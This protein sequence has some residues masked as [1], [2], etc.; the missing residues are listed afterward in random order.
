MPWIINLK[1]G[2]QQD[3]KGRHFRTATN[4]RGRQDII[5]VEHPTNAEKARMIPV[6]PEPVYIPKEK[7][8]TTD[9]GDGKK[10]NVIHLPKR[11]AVVQ[12]RDKETQ[13]VDKVE[14]DSSKEMLD[15]VDEHRAVTDP[16]DDTILV[17]EADWDWHGCY[18]I[19]VEDVK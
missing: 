7:F 9:S 3:C 17:H 2:I 6:P 8:V 19:E 10:R 11:K 13:A 16:L 4:S 1:Q 12:F 14:F 18:H 5:Y 15:F